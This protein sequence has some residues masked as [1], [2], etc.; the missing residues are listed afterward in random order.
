MNWS[1]RL[2]KIRFWLFIETSG[3]GLN[4]LP[5]WQDDKLVWRG[6][7]FYMTG[8]PTEVNIAPVSSSF[9]RPMTIAQLFPLL[10]GAKPERKRGHYD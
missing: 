2:T 9:S 5:S 3:H 8:Q 1:Q 6:S 4:D 10:P 7:D